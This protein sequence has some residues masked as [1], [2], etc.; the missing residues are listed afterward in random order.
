[1]RTWTEFGQ[2]PLLSLEELQSLGYAGV[3]M[4]VTLLRVA[5][6]AVEAARP[7]LPTRLATIRCSILM[8]TRQELYDLLATMITNNANASTSN[9]TS[10]L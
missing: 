8:Q 9:L 5:M 3:L 10:N 6:K 1:M 4:P 7:R 2:S